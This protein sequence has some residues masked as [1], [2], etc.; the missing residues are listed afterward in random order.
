MEI[1]S[2]ISSDGIELKYR[3]WKCE[4]ARSC[5]II[6]HGIQSHSGWYEASA[7]YLF[8]SGIEVAALDRRGSGMNSSNRG[9][10]PNFKALAE[11]IKVFIDLL[12]EKR[13]L[14]IRKSNYQ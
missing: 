3:Y 13:G 6:L 12:K 11:D 4:S 7:Q 1:S 9:D 5:A 14:E 10:T 8:S 2:Y